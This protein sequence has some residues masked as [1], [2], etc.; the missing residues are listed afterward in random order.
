MSAKPLLLL[1]VDGPLNPFEAST[2]P[3]GYTIHRVRPEGWGTALRLYL[4]PRH[5]RM[6]TQI[7][8]YVDLVWATAWREEANREIGPRIGLPELPVVPLEGGWHTVTAHIWK[9]DAVSAYVGERPFAWFDDDFTKDDLNWA[10]VRSIEV[11][12][13][14]LVSV[15]PQIGLVRADV[16]KVER[17]AHLQMV[18]NEGN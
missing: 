6:L 17:W 10:A 2:C 4:N 18:L 13:T 9:L 7:T 3:Q 14:F 16:D 5:G 12:P 1:D 11:A 15:D 8:R